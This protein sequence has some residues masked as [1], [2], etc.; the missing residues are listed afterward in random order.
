[1]P[2]TSA[3][4]ETRLTPTRVRRPPLPHAPSRGWGQD[5][6]P[7]PR[8]PVPPSPAPVPEPGPTPA[9]DPTPA[10]SPVPEPLT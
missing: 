9:P 8:P 10:P 1:M 2:T 6:P 3:S 5:P 4:P 7:P